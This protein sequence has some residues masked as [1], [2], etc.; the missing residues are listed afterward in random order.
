MANTWLRAMGFAVMLA[1]SLCAQTPPQ[2][3]GR[4]GGNAADRRG[5]LREPHFVPARQADF[6][7][8]SDLVIG[9]SENGVAKAYSRDVTAWHHVIHDTFGNMP[10]IVTW[11][12]LCNTPLVFKSEVEGRKLTFERTDNRGNNFIMVDKETGSVWQQVTGQAYEGPLKGKRLTIVPFLTTTWGEWRARNPQ[13]LALVPEADSQAGY[14]QMMT[15]FAEMPFGKDTMPARSPLVR[16]LDKRLPASEQVIGIEI[17]DAHKAYAISVLRRDALI[18]DRVGSTPVLLVH[19]AAS[20]TTTAFSRTLG[21]R[22]LTFK[23]SGAAGVL[24]DNETGSQW[25]TYG[26]CTSGS[27]RGQKLQRIVPQPGLWFAWA[28]FYPDTQVYSPAPR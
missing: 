6:L 28:E 20:E 22:T 10:V 7:K 13:T 27:L 2:R 18:N 11:C 23:A 26:E 12:S 4:G 14:A 24:A 5:A 16:D 21:A 19:A 15:R 25:N 9:V 1:A 8:D 3:G 17:G